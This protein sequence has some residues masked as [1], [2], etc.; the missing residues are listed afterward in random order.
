MTN[1]MVLRDCY[2]QPYNFFQLSPPGLLILISSSSH[3]LLHLLISSS[4]QMGLFLVFDSW[5]DPF[6][7]FIQRRNNLSEGPGTNDHFKLSVCGHNEEL[8]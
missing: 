8:Q 7:S 4:F 2:H 5:N 6:L 1:V 3:L